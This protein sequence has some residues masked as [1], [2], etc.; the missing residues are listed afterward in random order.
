MAAAAVCVKKTTPTKNHKKRAGA[1]KN[2]QTVWIEAQRHEG[3]EER[4]PSLRES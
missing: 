3:T 4:T 2:A 1:H